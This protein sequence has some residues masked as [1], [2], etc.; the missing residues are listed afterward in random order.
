MSEVVIVVFKDVQGYWKKEG[1]YP[2]AAAINPNFC[3]KVWLNTGKNSNNNIEALRWRK[4]MECPV[5]EVFKILL[6]GTIVKVLL[7]NEGFCYIR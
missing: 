1:N 2:S 5:L 3:L 6:S 7:L 4:I